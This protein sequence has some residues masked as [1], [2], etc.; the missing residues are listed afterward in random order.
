MTNVI[1]VE[2]VFN[3]VVTAITYALA[4]ITLYRREE[5]WKPSSQSYRRAIHT[6]GNFE[7][8]I[9]CEMEPG[10]LEAILSGMYGGSLPPPEEEVLYL[11]E[12]VNIICG[13]AVS[14]VNNATGNSSRLSVPF[15][16][17]PEDETQE[18]SNKTEKHILSYQTSQGSMCIRIFYTLH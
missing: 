8:Y 5:A 6:R 2:E 7:A 13:R 18:T 3:R 16:Y 10:L 14:I 4:N 17:T 15:S 1:D 9:I 12:Y 11:N